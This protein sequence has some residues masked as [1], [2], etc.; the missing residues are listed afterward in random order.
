M[1]GY[2]AEIAQLLNI[3]LTRK[4]KSKPDSPLMTGVNT[5]SA[6]KHIT[7]LIEQG[8]TVVIVNQI[9]KITVNGK[10]ISE[11]DVV[12]VHSPATYIERNCTENF[13]VSIHVCRDKLAIGDVYEIGLSAID[14]STGKNYAHHSIS[15]NHDSFYSIDDASRFIQTFQPTELIFTGDL[16]N[17]LK[18]LVTELDITTHYPQLKPEFKLNTFHN[19]YLHKYFPD[20]AHLDPVDYLDLALCNPPL[21]IH[22][23]LHFANNTT[24]LC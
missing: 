24:R 18:E 3:Q 11:R 23:M 4:D 21:F 6:S 15:R 1:P 20:H 9:G 16:K 17:N 13:L 19:Q 12:A 14:L 5:L 10:E 2:A 7:C 22:S 8:Y